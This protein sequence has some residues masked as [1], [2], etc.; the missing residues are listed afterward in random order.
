[1]TAES[2]QTADAE[3][4]ANW[5]EQVA[6]TARIRDLEHALERAEQRAADAH[7]RRH[8]AEHAAETWQQIAR[9][10][11]ITAACQ[12][13]HVAPER[14]AE[15]ERHAEETW[16]ARAGRHELDALRWRH[17]RAEPL[18]ALV[19][20]LTR[21]PVPVR[22]L[23]ADELRALVWAV[24]PAQ[25]RPVALPADVVS[26]VCQR[27]VQLV[28]DMAT[29]AGGMLPAGVTPEAWIVG[30]LARH[31]VA[32]PAPAIASAEQ[33]DLFGGAT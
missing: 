13:L 1:M 2:S 29:C 26:E 9:D 14:R 7:D 27:D 6:L 11:G 10:A 3:M 33:P 32:P 28:L 21:L 15:A 31:G 4:R 8:A 18:A 30:A 12:H 17:D 19:R 24:A 22:E 25:G 20:R 16:R 23:P 5:P